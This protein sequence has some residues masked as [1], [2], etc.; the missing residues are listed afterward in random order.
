MVEPG[1]SAGYT[2]C[3]ATS[4]RV[5]SPYKRIP[6]PDGGAATEELTLAKSEKEP[7]PRPATN[8]PAIHV[9]YDLLRVDDQIRQTNKHIA[10]AGLKASGTTI[11]KVFGV[12]PLCG[13]HRGR[14]RR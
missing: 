14:L 6:P 2:R 7:S 3:C 4:S 5:E 8:W 11:T 1:P 13:R 12:G 9:I 10:A